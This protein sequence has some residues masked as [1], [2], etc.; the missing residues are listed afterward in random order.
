MDGETKQ[1]R[2]TIAQ[3]TARLIA[4][5]RRDLLRLAV[6]GCPG[7]PAMIGIILHPDGNL[8]VDRR[9]GI[10]V[11]GRRSRS[12]QSSHASRAARKSP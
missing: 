8:W 12:P 5:L 1:P 9:G 3:T 10:H 4:G 11:A 6:S 7:D 2:A